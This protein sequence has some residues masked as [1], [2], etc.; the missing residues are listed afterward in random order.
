MAEF[1][2]RKHRDNVVHITWSK[3]G[4]RGRHLSRTRSHR[5][6]SLIVSSYSVGED[7]QLLHSIIYEVNPRAWIRYDGNMGITTRAMPNERIDC[8]YRGFFGLKEVVSR[9]FECGWWC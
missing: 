3:N 1:G 6:E 8:L 9:M 4:Y 5:D 2:K 7:V